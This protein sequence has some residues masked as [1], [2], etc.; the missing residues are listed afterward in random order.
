[1]VKRHKTVVESTVVDHSASKLGGGPVEPAARSLGPVDGRDPPK[2]ACEVSDPW[3]I[4]KSK[5]RRGEIM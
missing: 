5:R 1:M 2:A 3:P 4:W